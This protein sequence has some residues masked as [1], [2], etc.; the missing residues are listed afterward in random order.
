MLRERR[1]DKLVKFLEK[2]Y[3]NCPQLVDDAVLE[4]I[5]SALEVSER[6]P[7]HKVGAFI[8]KV[9]DRRV[10]RALR[11]ERLGDAARD[12]EEAKF[13]AELDLIDA[14]RTVEMLKRAMQ[15][16]AETVRVV[17][18]LVLDS[19]VQDVEL[20]SEDLAAEA[21]NLLARDIT[22]DEA[23][24]WKSRGL[25]KLREFLGERERESA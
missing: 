9:A 14:K 5:A 13:S 20:S 25:K 17:T 3:S 19:V 1:I 10:L 22:A 4:S 11:R 15:Q 2:K 23:R 18:G 16:W 12:T 24:V 6:R 8:A 7:I 21:S